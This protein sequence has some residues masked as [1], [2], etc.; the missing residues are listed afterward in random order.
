M[1]GSG[2]QRGPALIGGIVLGAVLASGVWLGKSYLPL[3]H[4]GHVDKTVE[5][6]PTPPTSAEVAKVIERQAGL[7]RMNQA[8]GLQCLSVRLNYPRPEV[9]GLPGITQRVYPGSYGLTLLHD[10]GLRMQGQRDQQMAQLNYLAA[11]GLL[12]SETISLKTDGGMRA[13]TRYTLTWSGFGALRQSY[14]NRLCFL[15]GQRQFTSVDSVHALSERVLDHPVFA[16]TYQT[17]MSTVPDWVAAPRASELFPAL[18]KQLDTRTGKA[19]LMQTGEGWQSLAEVERT[20]RQIKY[21]SNRRR[22]TARRIPVEAPEKNPS[23]AEIQQMLV[24]AQHQTR[25]SSLSTDVACL[26][27]ALGGA[28]NGP[29][30]RPA[31]NQNNTQQNDYEAVFYDV[32]QSSKSRQ[33]R[34][35]RALH[36]LNALRQAGMAEM[37]TIQSQE[38]NQAF[39][40]AARTVPVNTQGVRF[41]VPAAMARVLGLNNHY[42]D[43]IPAG[44]IKMSLLGHYRERQMIRVLAKGEVQDSPKWVVKLADHLPAL[45]SILET[46]VPMTARLYYVSDQAGAATTDADDQRTGHWTLRGR[47]RPHYPQPR[48]ERIPDDLAQFLPQMAAAQPKTLVPAPPI[49]Q[50]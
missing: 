38:V 3:D 16:V 35:A 6:G 40:H 11:Q 49:F 14:S 41:T 28:G 4:A 10:V 19:T 2:S 12:H 33:Y 44:K 42:P 26:P 15:I 17:G 36:M 8:M 24:T 23:D 5:K 43:C 9:Q 20:I 13:A 32:P 21:Q 18:S 7:G 30:H 1:N 31:P 50:D 48:Y 27:L 25:P 45:K 47:L 22:T 29:R 37:T 39:S 46:G 34:T